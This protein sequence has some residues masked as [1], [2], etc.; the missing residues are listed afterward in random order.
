MRLA[1]I[2]ILFILVTAIVFWNWA[3]SPPVSAGMGASAGQHTPPHSV[4]A[5]SLARDRAPVT[6]AIEIRDNATQHLVSDAV[7]TR[8]SPGQS[9]SLAPGELLATAGQDGVMSWSGSVG[10][11]DFVVAP[12][13]LP[14]RL[15]QVELNRRVVYLRRGREIRVH[16]HSAL[17]NPLAGVKITLRSNQSPDFSIGDLE[18]AIGHPFSSDPVWVMPTNDAGVA[19]IS[20]LPR[21]QFR[22]REWLPGH[23][24][25]TSHTAHRLVSPPANLSIAM[26]EVWGV[27]ATVPPGMEVAKWDWQPEGDLDN[28]VNV[29]SVLAP[30]RRV[31]ESL[32]PNSLCVVAVPRDSDNPPRM[33]CNATM[34][35]GTVWSVVWPLA[36]WRQIQPVFLEQD[37]AKSARQISFELLDPR[38]EAMNAELSVFDKRRKVRSP[39]VDG[40]CLLTHGEYRVVPSIVSPWLDGVVEG[41]N[42]AVAGKAPDGDKVY[43]RA[44]D[45]LF[46]LSVKLKLKIESGGAGSVV[47][48]GF[49]E[50]GGLNAT[51]MADVGRD[52][53]YVMF[54]PK[55]EI[56]VRVRGVGYE[57]QE[58]T[59]DVDRNQSFEIDLTRRQR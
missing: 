7:L 14:C 5:E 47:R 52:E 3:G 57:A 32:Y 45:Q 24:P 9:I 33:T 17:G 11:G 56:R 18:A 40:K 49:R 36:R 28:G 42:F 4:A 34:I 10:A 25:L 35:D 16:A 54:V 59:I 37:V 43:L 27:C 6:C 51:V 13:Y 41:A 38:G 44:R 55:G 21:K 22:L 31:L 50:A 1:A 2:T 53:P 26:G 20:G 23:Y 39:I 19:V 48:L 58:V 8:A 12:G 46:K 30:N 29:V 15:T